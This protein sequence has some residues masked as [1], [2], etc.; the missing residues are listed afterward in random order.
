MR[1]KLK[2]IGRMKQ[3]DDKKEIKKDYKDGTHES[4]GW[5]K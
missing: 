2:R 5:E 4:E 1:K 3:K